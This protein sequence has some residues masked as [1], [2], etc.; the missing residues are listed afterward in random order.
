MSEKFGLDWKKYGGKRMAEF[1][2]I[3]KIMNDEMNGGAKKEKP[4]HNFR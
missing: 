3:L 1:V 4:K 2:H